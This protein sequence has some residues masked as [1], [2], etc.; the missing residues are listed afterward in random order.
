MQIKREVTNLDPFLEWKNAVSVSFNKSMA[1]IPNGN[2]PIFNTC[3]FF[4]LM[5]FKG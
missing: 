5:S 2:K 4:F 1:V 3:F